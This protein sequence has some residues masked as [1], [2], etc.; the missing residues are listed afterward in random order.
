MIQIGIVTIMMN[1]AILTCT[2][3]EKR[4]KPC[5]FMLTLQLGYQ[6]VYH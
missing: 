6:A 5:L 1:V 2:D 4:R 3:R